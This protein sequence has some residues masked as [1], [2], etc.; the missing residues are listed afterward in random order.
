MGMLLAL[1]AAFFKQSFHLASQSDGSHWSFLF[2][3]FS[4][5]A[6][7]CTSLSFI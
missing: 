6:H 1:S 5:L 2:I 7:S 4:G 3:F